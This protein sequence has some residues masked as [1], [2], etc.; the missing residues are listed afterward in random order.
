ML[1]TTSD[2][3]AEALTWVQ[4]LTLTEPTY[5]YMNLLSVGNALSRIGQFDPAPLLWLRLQVVRSINEALSD[6]QRA[7]HVGVILTV[8]RIASHEILLGDAATGIAMH[9]PAQ[10]KMIE[11]AGGLENLGLPSLVY[12]HVAWADR[13]MTE[14]TGVSM[15]QLA[16]AAV[17]NGLPRGNAARDKQMLYTYRPDQK[18]LPIHSVRT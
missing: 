11:M 15:E 1:D 13:L 18:T 7:A 4:R 9:R 5:F 6:P 10:V 14:R 3:R 12:K 16:P 2:E 8:G 17:R